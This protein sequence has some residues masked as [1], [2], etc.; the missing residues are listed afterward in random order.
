MGR[1]A[2]GEEGAQGALGGAVGLG[3]GRG[4]ALGL[5]QQGGPEKGA[6]DAARQIGGRFGGLDEPRVDQGSGAGLAERLRR[7]AITS[8]RWPAL[9]MPP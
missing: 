5:D 4:V 8:A 3:D 6:D 2:L 7:K 9:L 1:E